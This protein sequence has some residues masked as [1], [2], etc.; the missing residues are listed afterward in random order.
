M[1]SAL[2]RDDNSGP[3]LAIAAGEAAEE[4]GDYL[5]AAA[6]YTRAALGT[7][8]AQAA[9]AH[10]RIARVAWRQGRHDRALG[11]YKRA[12][13]LG[14]EAGRADLEARAENGVGVVHYTR[15]EYAQA[16]AS[17]QLATT[18]AKDPVLLGQFQLNLG[19]LAEM[20]GDLEGALSHYLRA[21][22]VFR[23]HSAPTSETLALRNLGMIYADRQEWDAAGDAYRQCL[24]LSEAQGN[25]RMI[26]DVLLNASEVLVAHS[27]FAGAVR[28]CQLARSIYAELGD[29]MGRGEALRWQG[30]AH[31]KGGNMEAAEEALTEAI[32]VAQRFRDRLLEAEASREMAA[33]H[34]PRGRRDAPRW[35]KRAVALFYEL[36]ATRELTAMNAELEPAHP[37]ERE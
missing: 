11:E 8:P 23:D 28:N 27:D 3:Q 29:E 18:L 5:A 36:G 37:P 2:G 16:R 17:Y 22:A 19:A 13:A 14:A 31:R 9:E 1:R 21:R 33:L 15:G 20:E 32:L 34:H 30:H 26:A 12:R 6:A 25:R 7:G 4:L 35:R 24:A 10:L